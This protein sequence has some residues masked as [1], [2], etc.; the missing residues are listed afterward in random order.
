MAGNRLLVFAR[1]PAPVQVSWLAYPGTTG[2][3]TID[4]RFTDP[5]IDPPGLREHDYSEESILL[6]NAFW[7]YD[8]LAEEPAISAVPAVENG[9][10]T[11]GCLNNFC[12]VNHWV[13]KVW[14][15][16]LT[17]VDESRLLLLAPEGSVRRHTLDLLER[18]GV[19]SEKVTF[20]ARQPRLQY[21]ELYHR[22][23]IGLD[24]FPY[25]GHTTSLD[26]FW[27]GVPVVTLEGDSPVARAG[28]SLLTNLGLSELVGETPD[29]FVS[30]AV[31]LAGD[32]PRLCELRATLRD[33]LQ[34][35]PL[36]DASRFAR[37]VEAAYREMWRRWCSKQAAV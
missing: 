26:A 22:I 10:I 12:K 30:I 17:A 8:P 13:L 6:P 36:S 3:S 35:S 24:T 11:F 2:L 34:A 18:E 27:Q 19:K 21:L 32:V 23:D 20:V 29:Q 4:Y 1:K 9:C 5:Y 33:G 31:A 7:C 15:Q 16:V 14:A 37:G 25:N 28:L